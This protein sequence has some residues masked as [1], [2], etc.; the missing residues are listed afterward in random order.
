MVF[1][2][3]NISFRAKVPLD[4]DHA[5]RM[6]QHCHVV[7]A[8]SNSCRFNVICY[9]GRPHQ[10]K[11]LQ[12]RLVSHSKLSFMFSRLLPQLRAFAGPKPSHKLQSGI[13]TAR[14]LYG[15]IGKPRQNGG[16]SD[17]VF[18]APVKHGQ[19]RPGVEK[20][21]KYLKQ[22]SFPPTVQIVTLDPLANLEL[23]EHRTERVT[24]STNMV[25]IN[26][27]TAVGKSNETL[28]RSIVHE[29]KNVI[30]QHRRLP[31]ILTLGGDHSLSIGSVSAVANLC[32]QAIGARLPGL[33]FSDPE[34]V[35]IW[36]DAH[37][38]I[39]TPSTTL[40]GNLHGCPLSLLVGL[41]CKT[42]RELHAF[43]WAFDSTPP[44]KTSFLQV[45]HLAYIGLRAVDKG[46][47]DIIA[48][49]RIVS[50]N[51]NAV[52][53][54]GRNMK[55]IIA[56]CL[57]SVDPKGTRPIL[58]S[59][60]IDAIDPKY[61]PSTGTPVQNG[62]YPGEGTQIIELLKATGRLV[63]MDLTEVN[64]EIGDEYDISQTLETSKDLID[65]WFK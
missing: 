2:P 25:P 13:N 40:S 53:D 11:K 57:E 63:A 39:N 29:C 23:N 15:T 45:G 28:H 54:A 26:D 48:N 44:G 21:P 37:A 34:L 47:K 35:V 64:P 43:D 16:E 17:Y 56:A 61:A 14:S 51:M 30:S 52:N 38:D 12:P 65:V 24:V 9:Q 50:F 55:K 3:D 18:L 32:A 1:T 22:Y 20:G 46:E 5:D 36:V 31:S 10:Y 33:P 49:K 7:G 60:D 8:P 27:P 4:H 6:P 41:D 58:L 19:P 59:F 62:L 42:W